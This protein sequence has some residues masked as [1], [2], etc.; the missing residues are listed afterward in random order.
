[1]TRM[2]WI[3]RPVLAVLST[4][5]LSLSLSAQAPAGTPGGGQAPPPLKNLQVMSKDSTRQDVQAM[6]GAF[7]QALGVGCNH[8]HVDDEPDGRPNDMASDE[9]RPKTVARAMMKLTMDLNGRL[10]GVVA[11]EAAATMHVGCATCH[12]G[13]AI[14]KQIT[15]ILSETA[16]ATGAP[17]AIEQYKAL[18]KK[19]YGGQAYDFSEG[20][21]VSFAGRATQANKADEALTWLNLNLEFY[22]NSARTYLGLANAFNRKGDKAQ[23]ITN[24]EKAVALDPQNAMAKRTLDSLKK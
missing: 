1:M 17:A 19:Y 10:P 2:H 11:K 6:M 21:L 24:A 5:S 3:V 8:C 7:T 20:A 9:K 15:E 14:P 13:V 16:A 4:A 22:P 12:R 23:A 18:R